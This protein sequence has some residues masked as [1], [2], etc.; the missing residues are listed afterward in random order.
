MNTRPKAPEPWGVTDAAELYQVAAWG[1]GYFAVGE[2]GRLRVRP[3]RTPGTEVD[4]MDVVEG[5]SARELSPPLLIRF[6]DIL[7]DRL[8][9]LHDAFEEAI[10]EHAYDGNY[11]AVY[12]IKVNQQRSVVEEVY[13]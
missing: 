10:E 5:L 3:D 11:L 9:A 4:L 1:Q 12:P 2:D 7:A 6:S 13:R 8:L